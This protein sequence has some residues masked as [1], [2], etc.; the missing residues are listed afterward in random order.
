[1]SEDTKKLCLHQLIER[2]VRRTPDRVALV[3]EGQRLKYAELDRRARCLAAWLRSRGAGPEVLV[4]LCMERS[5]DMIVAMLAILKAGAAYV[6]IDAGFPEARI[7]YVL[8]DSGAKLLLTQTNALPRLPRGVPETLCVDSFDWTAPHEAYGEAEVGPQH[9]AY[10]IYTSG[11]T[12]QPKGVCIE[13]R[14]IV[15]YTTGVAQ[16]LQFEPGMHHAMV[17]SIA[18]DLG[19]TVIFPAL[20]TGGCLHVIAQECAENQALL[21][22]YFQREMIDVLKVAPSHLAA[23]QSGRDPGRVMP[24]RRLILG[25]EPSTLERIEW[26]RS[27]APECRIYNHY[28][29]T[30]TTVGVLTYEVG[31]QLPATPSATLPLGYPLPN[32]RVYVLGADGQ[33]AQAGEPGELCIGGDGVGRGYL[34]R[35]ELTASKFVSDPFSQEPGARMYRSGDLARTLPEGSVEF[36]GRA[37]NQVKLF[38]HRIELEEIEQALR[39]HGGVRDAVVLARED[40]PGAKHLVAYVAPKRA[41]QGLWNLPGIHVLPDGSPVAHLNRSETDY[42]YNEIFALQAYLRHGIAVNDG[43]C[44]LDV[45]ANIGLFTLFASRLARNLRII[46]FEPNPAAFACLQAN[47]EAWG[48]GVKCQPFGISS[49]NRSADLTFFEGM[50]LLSGF[51]ADAAAERAMVQTYLSNQQAGPAADPQLAAQVGQLIDGR[52]QAK[53]VPARLRT[54]SS[55]IAEEGIER[56]DLLKVNVEKSELDVLRGLGAADWPKIRQLVVEVDRSDYLPPI[57]ELLERQGFECLSEQDPLLRD[58]EICYVYAIR[59]QDGRR[60]ARQQSATDHLRPLPAADARVLTPASLRRHLG[61][62][63]PR[64]MVP[65]VFVLVERFPLL[66]SGK[67]DRQ[68]L[69]A[70][71]GTHPAADFVAPR[72][73]TEKKLAAIWRELLEADAIGVNDDFFD[74]GGQSLLAIRMVAR[75]RDE[76]GV[77][78]QLR[79]LFETPTLAGL[80]E[81]IDGLAWIRESDA[82]TRS[83]GEREEFAL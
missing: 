7:A 46:A 65:Q 45:G 66:A 62:H 47:A 68:A 19:N 20:S 51:Y 36:C 54:L 74:L 5:L 43:D 38:G 41:D 29:P 28:G 26:L 4:A 81:I 32:S 34:N 70:A 35:A 11:S 25:G 80:A 49:E 55:V 61:E 76:F 18:A 3:F 2:Q 69:P 40:R 53:L 52:L 15:S 13:H 73:E 75:I 21:S 27:L 58:T 12:G 17:S 79:N 14:N 33:P 8:Q 77:D 1:M 23:L 30:E 24:A 6:P 63:L 60:L 64:Y 72:S 57:T 37:D 71:E 10:V 16:R 67:L 22:E 56:I 50:S 44:I 59:P 39:A 82:P 42:I 31:A 9:L 78:V 83:A 48:A